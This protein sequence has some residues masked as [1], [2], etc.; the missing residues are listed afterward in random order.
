VK[1]RNALEGAPIKK[2]VA[3]PLSDD[4]LRMVRLLGDNHDVVPGRSQTTGK[5]G[6][7][8][9]RCPRLR[10]KILRDEENAH[11]IEVFFG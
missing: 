10:R 2:P 11:I 3:I 1:Y 8:V 9:G 7:P 5:G 6:K 4:A